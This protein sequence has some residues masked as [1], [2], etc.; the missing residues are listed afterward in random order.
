[1]TFLETDLSPDTLLELAPGVRTRLDRTRHVLVDS[2]VGTIIDIGPGG[3]GIL[4]LFSQ[5][6]RLGD[7][8][9]RLEREHDTRPTSRRR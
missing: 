3:F 6:T 1:M 7:A 8:I 2:P 5:P 9:D 4:S